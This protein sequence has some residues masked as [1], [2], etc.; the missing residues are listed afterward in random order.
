MCH[1]IRNVPPLQ[2]RS[3]ER[4]SCSEKEKVLCRKFLV[5]RNS[6]SCALQH[7]RLA[8]PVLAGSPVQVSNLVRPV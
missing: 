5:I 1:V 4:L 6:L 2:D 8:H 3:H 7:E